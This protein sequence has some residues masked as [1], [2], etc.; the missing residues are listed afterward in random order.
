LRAK[1]STREAAVNEIA[2]R[3]RQFVDIFEKARAQ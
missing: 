2:R 1:K 3:Y